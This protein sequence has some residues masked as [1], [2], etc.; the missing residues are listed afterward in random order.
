M[1]TIYRHTQV[2]RATVGGMGIAWAAAVWWSFR[3]SGPVPVTTAVLVGFVLV[4]FSTLTVIVRDGAMDV[5]F[6]AGADSPA[7][8]PA[9]HPR[10]PGGKNPLVLR[11]GHSADSDRLAVERV[12]AGWSGGPIDDRHRFRVGSDEPNRLAEALHRELQAVEHAA[13]R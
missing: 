7:H 5:F 10:G 13:R 11:L 1:G 9:S 2:S 8:S 4:L 12:G 6:R 3:V